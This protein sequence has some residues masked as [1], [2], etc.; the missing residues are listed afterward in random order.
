MSLCCSKVCFCDYPS[1]TSFSCL[2]NYVFG[3]VCSLYSSFPGIKTK[4]NLFSD[5]WSSLFTV[6]VGLV[7]F[8]FMIF[9]LT[10]G[11]WWSICACSWRSRQVPRGRVSLIKGLDLVSSS[12]A[13]EDDHGYIWPQWSHTSNTGWWNLY[14]QITHFKY[15]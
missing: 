15:L 5:L 11:S 3:M 2:H 1:H 14:S 10:F 13:V 12:L 9:L 7:I 6:E 8:C 4:T